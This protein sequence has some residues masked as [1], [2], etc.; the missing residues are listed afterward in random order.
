MK[1]ATKRCQVP[2]TLAQGLVVT[3]TEDDDSSTTQEVMAQKMGSLMKMLM[4]LS[5]RVKATETQQRDRA[6][7]SIASP[8]ISHTDVRRAEHQMTPTQDPDQS[9]EVRR[10]L[11]QR[12]QQFPSVRQSP[13]MRVNQ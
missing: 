5:H 7:S 9:E 1:K 3:D 4:D 10:R 2:E 13:Q 11:A 8:S 12:F 6:T